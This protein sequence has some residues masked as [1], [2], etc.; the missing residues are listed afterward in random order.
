MK[1]ILYGLIVVV[2]AALFYQLLVSQR[3]GVNMD[4][5]SIVTGEGVRAPGFEGGGEWIN[6]EPLS[7]EELMKENKLVLVDFW[8]YS[9]INCQ[10][11]I[12]YL[13]QWWEKYKDKGLVIVGVHSPEFEFEKVKANV[14][15]AT[16]KYGVDWP[17]VQ[18]N[19]MKIWQA[20]ANHYW[21]AKYMVMPPNGEIVYTHFGEGGY[22]ETEAL[23]R[24]KLTALGYDLSDVEMGNEGE[25]SFVRGQ[26]PETYLGWQ[27]GKPGNG[28]ELGIGKMMEYDL[29]PETLMKNT[30]YFKGNWKIE[31]EFAESGE[32][33]ELWYKFY[34]GEANLVMSSTDE[35][36]KT[37]EVYADGEKI[38]MV[39]V[40]ADDLYNLYKGEVKEGVLRLVMEP[41]VKTFAFTFG[42]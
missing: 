39:K 6:S 21:P 25:S 7:M 19:D 41:G 14:E 42:K 23:I 37:V 1:V 36:E 28:G 27:R 10:R 3:G 13:K 26:S 35:N 40:K 31:S 22:E 8:T 11:T 20:Y 32:E 15:A 24:T 9:C 5:K 4:I 38:K 16:K 18:D 30:A 33:A 17:V 29:N 34:G 2:V 12:P